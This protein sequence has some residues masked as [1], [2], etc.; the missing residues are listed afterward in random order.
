MFAVET[1]WSRANSLQNHL[2]SQYIESDLLRGQIS[3]NKLLIMQCEG[4]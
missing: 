1:L 2:A 4:E 3:E